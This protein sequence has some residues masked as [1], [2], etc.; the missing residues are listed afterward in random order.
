MRKTCDKCRAYTG[1]PYH[2]CVLGF[3]NING[4][5]AE[6]CPKPIT[7]ARLIEETNKKNKGGK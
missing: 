4:I 6:K 2:F 7:N 5:P 3:T 1:F